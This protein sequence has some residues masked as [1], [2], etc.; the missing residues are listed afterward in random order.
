MLADQARLSQELE[1]VGEDM[2]RMQ[3][4]LDALE[5]LNSQ[6]GRGQLR[7]WVTRRV[8]R[9]GAQGGGRGTEGCVTCVGC[10]GLGVRGSQGCG[11]VQVVWR[12]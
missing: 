1:V 3:Q 6:V 11:V 5:K 4:I 2:E 9:R 8:T 7:S 12:G 10:R